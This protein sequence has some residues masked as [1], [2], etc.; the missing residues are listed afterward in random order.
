M[1]KIFWHPT[2]WWRMLWL[3]LTLDIPWQGPWFNWVV[4]LSPTP[5]NLEQVAISPMSQALVGF[6]H[7]P[8]FEF[9]PLK[10]NIVSFSGWRPRKGQ[11]SECT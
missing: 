4:S 9:L 11:R 2:S 8:N 3:L 5:L 7:S 6:V 1:L 10:V